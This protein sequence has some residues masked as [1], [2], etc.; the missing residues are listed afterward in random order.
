MFCL[1]QI[2]RWFLIDVI[3]RLVETCGLKEWKNIDHQHITADV[4]RS[5][6]NI[7]KVKKLLLTN[8][9]IWSYSYVTWLMFKWCIC[10]YDD[11]IIIEPY[12][13]KYLYVLKY[14]VEASQYL[15]GHK[16]RKGDCQSCQNI[17]SKLANNNKNHKNGSCF[18]YLKCE[19]GN[20]K[21]MT[22]KKKE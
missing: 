2:N 9:D 15:R 20:L 22:L 7:L 11:S 4:C 13:L 6:N 1:I 16:N 5:G 18:F 19:T 8:L 12:R 10:L 14:S 3:W 21:S 17:P